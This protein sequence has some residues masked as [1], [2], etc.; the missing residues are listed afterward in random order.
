MSSPRVLVLHN[1]YR[2]A[3]GEER[4]VELHLRSLRSAGVEHRLLERSSS[5]TGRG[6]AARA[7][8]AGGRDPGEV[9]D[10]VR[11]LGASVAHFHNMQPLLGPRA[12]AAARDAGA[13]VVLHLHNFRLFCAIGV[14]F[15]DGEPCFRCRRGLTIP[16]LAL[17]CRGALPESAVYAAALSRQL[18]AVL[19]AVDL[20]VA[21]SRWA[22]EQLVRLGVPRGRVES[23]P[24]YLPAERLAD[25]SR[26][27]AGEYA[28]ALGRLTPEKGIET[29]IEAAAAAGVPL[30]VAGDGPLR[31]DLARLAAA[32]RAPVEMLG[33][34]PEAELRV[35][36]R[37][38]AMQVVPT[39]G[40]ET[41]GLVAL[42]AMGAALPVVGTRAGAL[43]EVAGAES[44]VPRD[45]PAAL[46]EAMSELW[47]HPERRRAGG[48]AALARARGLF[49]EER[50][51]ERLLSLYELACG[52]R[53][54]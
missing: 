52:L 16:G 12:L 19:D 51:R 10:A 21:P 43:P 5:D 54:T 3:G 32:R 50:F 27:D 2:L 31:G 37:D 7:L 24:H 48:D 25:A 6:A 13:A 26:A 46:A 17:N 18:P 53:Q 44:C 38:A 29:A 23:L 22:V 11:S 28:L 4:A 20:F 40:H 15:R 33:R 35:L 39:R 49:S 41:F 1:R 8:L 45:D 30:R 34:V 42:E 47:G 9:G 14:A 36:R